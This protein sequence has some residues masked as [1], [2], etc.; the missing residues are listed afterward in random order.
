MSR[1]TAQPLNSY[2]APGDPVNGYVESR[3]VRT[4]H[5]VGLTLPD[6]VLKEDVQAT[7]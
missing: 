7:V 6:T 3:A 4:V 5:V 1:E 2:A